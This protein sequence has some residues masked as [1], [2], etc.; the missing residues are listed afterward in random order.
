MLGCSFLTVWA[1]ALQMCATVAALL[2]SA[3][4]GGYI[5]SLGQE[6]QECVIIVLDKNLG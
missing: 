4:G 5:V 6:G 2:S 3:V 1:K